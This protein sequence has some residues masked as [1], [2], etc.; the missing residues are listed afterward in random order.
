MRWISLSEELDASS[1]AVYQDR[2]RGRETLGGIIQGKQVAMLVLS[3]ITATH[4]KTL[5]KMESMCYL[6]T[7]AKQEMT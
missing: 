4:P 7:L 3:G 2:G 1:P 6:R 5:L